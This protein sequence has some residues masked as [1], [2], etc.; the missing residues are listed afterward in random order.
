MERKSNVD[1]KHRDTDQTPKRVDPYLIGTY[2]KKLE[3]SISAPD[4]AGKSWMNLVHLLFYG[5][6][7]SGVKIFYL[8]FFKAL[9]SSSYQ[10]KKYLS[11]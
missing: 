5:K 11:F 3:W 2:W 9:L 7:C 10:P 8:N 1:K 6:N 4:I